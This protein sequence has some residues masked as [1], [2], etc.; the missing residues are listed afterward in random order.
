MYKVRRNGVACIIACMGCGVL[1][2]VWY[3]VHAYFL[4]KAYLLTKSKHHMEKQLKGFFKA[5]L[6]VTL[7]IPML[8]YCQEEKFTVPKELIPQVKQIYPRIFSVSYGNL[9]N[10]GR[11]GYYVTKENEDIN[12]LTDNFIKLPK[13]YK[14]SRGTYEDKYV[15]NELVNAETTH[16]LYLTETKYLL[17]KDSSNDSIYAI[18]EDNLKDIAEIATTKTL[19]NIVNKL[20]YKEYQEGE[21]FYIKTKTSEIR[22]DNRTKMELDK[23]PNYIKQLDADQ[24]QIASLVKQTVSHSKTLDKYLSLYRIQKSKISTANINAWRTATTNAQKLML[25]INKLSEK[26]DGNYSFTLLN[27]SNT[28]DIFSDNLLASKGVLRM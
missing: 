16:Y 27:K 28:L 14:L 17:I 24:L 15:T 1:D 18:S 6:L 12:F 25:Q 20:G 26:Y 21:D 5:S 9:D 13:K 10:K 19:I 23:N 11:Q 7:S 8:S 4:H 22:L 2:L 3:N